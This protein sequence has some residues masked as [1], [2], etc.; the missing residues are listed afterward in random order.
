MVTS[1]PH[2]GLLFSVLVSTF[3]NLPL[4]A[5]SLKLLP[6]VLSLTCMLTSPF[7]LSHLICYNIP[8]WVALV[9]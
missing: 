5:S 8:E 6:V 2:F 3:K 9:P 1:I 4:L 7:F